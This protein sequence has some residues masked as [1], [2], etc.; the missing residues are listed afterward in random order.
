M[1][2][3][4]HWD[5]KVTSLEGVKRGKTW[6]GGK[7]ERSEQACKPNSVS[8]MDSSMKDGGH[9]SRLFITE[10]LKRPD[11]GNLASNQRCEKR[12]HPCS[13]LLRVGFAKL[14]RSSG[15]LVSSY[16]T[17][18]PLPLA[19]RFP[20]CGTFHIPHMGT[21]AVSNHPALRSSD[22]PLLPDYGSSDHPACS[23]R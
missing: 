2:K 10:Q 4:S 15:T 7:K 9:S 3:T 17:L 5:T 14:S 23:D 19:G 8:S 12:S 16:L 1:I 22:F 21:V 6:W 18:S 11:P 20:F 13:V